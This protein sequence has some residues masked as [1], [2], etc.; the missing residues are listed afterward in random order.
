MDSMNVR[1][2][3]YGLTVAWLIVA[4]YVVWL[5]LANRKLLG[6]LERLKKLLETRSH[7]N[8]TP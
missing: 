2:L 7:S 1:F 3:F 4:V 5:G 6:E 8:E